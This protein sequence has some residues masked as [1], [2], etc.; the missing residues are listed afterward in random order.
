M[1]V[2]VQMFREGVLERVDLVVAKISGSSVGEDAN[3]NCAK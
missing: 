3:K 2:M 1:E